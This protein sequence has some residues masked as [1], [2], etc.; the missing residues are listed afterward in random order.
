MITPASHSRLHNSHALPGD[1]NLQQLN[2][3]L[4]QA[5]D[6]RSVVGVVAAGHAE[7]LAMRVKVR[8]RKT[9]TLPLLRTNSAR[10]KI[11]L[12]LFGLL[13]AL[14]AGNVTA[15]PGSQFIEKS[16]K[17]IL[18]RLEK[19][20]R[21]AQV[22][23]PPRAVRLAVFKEERRTELWLPDN[24]GRW[25]YVKTWTFSASSGKQGPK[26]Y[27]GDLQIPEGIY[28]IDRM[29]PSK[30][31]HLAL[32][33][34]YPNDFDRAM[35]ALEGRDPNYVSTGIN[36]HGGA[37]SYGCVVIGDRNIEELFL[38]AH[39]AGQEN[40]HVYIF[41]HDTD[42]TQPQF[43][44]CPECPVWYGDLLRHLSVAVREFAK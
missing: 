42:R 12:A 1:R 38:L 15:Q 14:A 17:R 44:S 29:E 10:S 40:T 31:Y 2:L 22:P 18:Q 5:K 43:K 21:E 37:I 24:Q 26:I 9:M 13:A 23:Y 30:E 8:Q 28:G 19:D 4:R 3:H 36:V 27:Y 35:L 25:R 41:P 7:I 33:V 6:P 16:A 11:N 32:H 20:L 39:K 34:N